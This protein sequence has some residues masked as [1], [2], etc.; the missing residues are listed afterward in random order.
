M[1]P[2]QI[3]LT[4]AY[5]AAE[6]KYK[7]EIKEFTDLCNAQRC[8]LCNSQ[9]DGTIHKTMASL[10]CVS[11]NEEYKATFVPGHID[12]I[13]ENIT[14]WYTQY[15]YVISY[16]YANPGSKTVITRMNLDVAPHLRY[17]SQ[18]IVFDYHG[19][20]LLFFRSRMEEDIF[21]KKLK[22]YNLFS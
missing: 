3:R 15:M 17:K 18:K 21:L 14:Y 7:A 10:Y 1:T 6:L 5:E 8:P 12:P 4:E 13:E 9:L 22:T 20:R 11:N 2:F 16:T 19:D